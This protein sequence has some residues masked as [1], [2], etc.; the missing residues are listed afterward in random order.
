MDISQVREAIVTLLS[1]SPNLLGKYIFPDSTQVPAVYVAGRQGVPPEWKVEGLEV[2]I[3]E[4]PSPNPRAILAGG[5]DRQT[6]EVV[7][8]DYL[9]SSENLRL[10]IDRM[11]SRWPDARFS[12]RA[13][14][15]VVYGQCRITIPDTK[16]FRLAAE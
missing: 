1:D 3:Q 8:T 7:I 6:W 4:F 16:T 13:E 11:K 10:A 12:F 9:P 5:L 14:T 15:D 2:V